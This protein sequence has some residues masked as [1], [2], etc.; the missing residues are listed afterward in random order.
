MRTGSTP[1]RLPVGSRFVDD[2]HGALATF[3]LFEM[4][5]RNKAYQMI[6]R[7]RYDRAECDPGQLEVL[8]DFQRRV[9]NGDDDAGGDRYQ[10]DRVAE[11]D[12]VLLPDFRPEQA[13]HAVQHDRDSAQY[14]ARR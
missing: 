5:R 6:G 8:R 2:H 12:A 11:I 4:R 13:D 14:A 10:V 3:L 9:T 7:N 1:S